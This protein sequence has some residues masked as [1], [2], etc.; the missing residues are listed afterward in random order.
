MVLESIIYSTHGL[1]NLVG[2]PIHLLFLLQVFTFQLHSLVHSSSS[3]FSP[4][5]MYFSSLVTL[6]LGLGSVANS[7]PVVERAVLPPAFLLVGGTP[8]SP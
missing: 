7:A 2:F 1:Y 8:L 3:K 5:N 4:F 6:A